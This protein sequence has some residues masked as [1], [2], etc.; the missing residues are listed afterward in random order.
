MK[1]TA[2]VVSNHWFRVLLWLAV[3]VV[4]ILF[5]RAATFAERDEAER[6][7]PWRRTVRLRSEEWES[8]LAKWNKEFA[9]EHPELKSG[10][11][12]SNTSINIWGF[13]YVGAK[14][15]NTWQHADLAK[16]IA[17]QFQPALE[18]WAAAYSNRLPCDVAQVTATYSNAVLVALLPH[19]SDCAKTLELPIIQPIT[20]AHVSKFNASPLAD[21]VGGGLWLTNGYWFV[22]S[23]GCVD[24]F[25]SPNN[26][27]TMQEVEDAPKF[28]G[29]ENMTTNEAVQF[30]RDSFVKLGYKLETFHLN[31]NPTHLEGSYDLPLGH[32]PFCRV[33]WESPDAT[34]LAERM[35]SYSVRFDIDLQRKLVVGMVLSGTNFYRPNL[36]VSVKAESESDFQKRTKM[37]LNMNTNA[38]PKSILKPHK[39]D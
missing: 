12:G 26:W 28:V 15:L 20:T 38:P 6:I 9:A 37:K 13:E 1:L 31:D 35:N 22:Y 14:N 10:K 19:V 17:E 16:K 8:G 29:K 5:W 25:R 4:S 33:L 36:E 3:P 27:F 7:N 23:H 24:S 11:V 18:R 30:A 34:T 32:I 2:K 21:N 39:A